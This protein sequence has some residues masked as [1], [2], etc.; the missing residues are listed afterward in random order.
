M[1]IRPVEAELFNAGEKDGQ[2]DMTKLTVAFRK[3]L[4]APKTRTGFSGKWFIAKQNLYT[5]SNAAPFEPQCIYFKH[6]KC[7]KYQGCTSPRRN[8]RQILYVG[9]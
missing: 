2:T 8:V 9:A 7:T 6:F 1:K 3:F 5:I 4:N